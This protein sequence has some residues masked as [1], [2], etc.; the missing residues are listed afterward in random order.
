MLL[1]DAPRFFVGERSSLDLAAALLQYCSCLIDVGSNMGLYI[2]YLRGRDLSTK[3]IYFFEPDPALFSRLASNI[4]RN[5]F[6]NVE[7]F[8]VAMA[9]KVGRANFFQNRTDDSSGSLVEEDWSKHRLEPIAVETTSFSTFVNERKLEHVCA[10][11]DVEGA[12]ELFVNGARSSLDKLSFLI[13]EILGPAIGRSL[14]TRVIKE[15]KVHGYYINDYCL[16]HSVAGEFRYVAPF[17]NWLFC[18]EN[19]TALRD[20]LIQ[21]SFRVI[22]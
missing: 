7:G 17:Y 20:K 12:E 3:P 6:R 22:D 2:F 11:V 19:P 14:P 4:S 5:G 15:G 1:F 10:K 21:T 9:E 8:Q 18:K 16:E 13:I